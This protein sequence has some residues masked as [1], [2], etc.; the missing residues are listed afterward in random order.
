MSER[1]QGNL[2]F[3]VNLN[4]VETGG[5]VE[6]QMQ[7]SHVGSAI[8]QHALRLANAR[9]L[10]IDVRGSRRDSV[11]VQQRHQEVVA[12]SGFH[13]EHNVA[14]FGCG[15]LGASLGGLDGREGGPS[16]VQQ[17]FTRRRERHSSCRAFEEDDPEPSLQLLNCTRK[18]R[19]RH[20]ELLGG[21]AEVQLFGNGDEIAKLSCLHQPKLE[22]FD[23]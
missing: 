10:H 4:K 9:E 12:C 15:T 7:Q 14:G 21:A 3:R 18:R 11:G 17:D 13:G 5:L 1:Q 19:L 16:L 2:I 22:V 6:G 23:T 8:A 20:L